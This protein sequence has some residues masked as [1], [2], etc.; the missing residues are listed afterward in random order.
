MSW[1]KYEKPSAKE[2]RRI[3]A[4]MCL[5]LASMFGAQSFMRNPQPYAGLFAVILLCV[6]AFHFWRATRLTS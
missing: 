1:W 5:I 4:W 2:S 3:S 6:S